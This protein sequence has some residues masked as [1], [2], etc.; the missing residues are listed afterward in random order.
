MY[1]FQPGG[2]SVHTQTTALGVY[3]AVMPTA[4]ADIYFAK[5]LHATRSLSVDVT[6]NIQV[7]TCLKC[8]SA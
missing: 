5:T 1:V 2:Y 8:S 7:G 3:A 6:D 4:P